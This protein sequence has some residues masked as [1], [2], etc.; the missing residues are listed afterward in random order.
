M[1]KPNLFTYDDYR[2]YLRDWFN[3]MKETKPGFS[4]R[5]FSMW[6]NFKS[7]NHLMLVI[8]GERNI[9]LNTLGRYFEVLKLKHTEKKYFE[10]LVKFNQAKD[11]SAKTEYFKELSFYWLK[12]GSLLEPEQLQYLSNWY[13][14]AIRE[15]VN[16][17][18]FKEDGN[19]ISRKLGGLVSPPNARRAIEILLDLKLLK[20]D[21]NGRLVQTS[22]YVTTGDE[23]ESVSAFLY[24]EQMIKLAMES[25]RVK[26]SD[27]RNLTAL[28][29]TIRKSDYSQVVAEI[30]D[31]RK[32]IIASLQN[33][34][35]QDQDDELYQLN[36]HLFPI[37]RS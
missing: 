30:N 24:H 3:W 22:N 29:F 14:T 23:V 21:S 27:V 10:L 36:I 20:R 5:A 18:E 25:L 8:K 4:Y 9:A 2:K 13:Y 11:M 15:L 34:Q 37:G 31:F 35:V 19:W 28:T 17:K 7:P 32:K 33:R 26:T 16:L 12:K 6:A 1:T